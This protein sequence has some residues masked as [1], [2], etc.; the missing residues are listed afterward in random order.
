MLDAAAPSV[1]DQ[2][3]AALVHASL[4]ESDAAFAAL[5]SVREWKAFA[6]EYLRY[7]FPDV[8]GPLRADPRYHAV[9]ARIDA[10]WNSAQEELTES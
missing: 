2:V 9:V 3:G 6:V 10:V 7:F 4:G 5:E 1:A 8:L